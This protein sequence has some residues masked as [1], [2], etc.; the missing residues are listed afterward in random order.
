MAWIECER[1]GFRWDSATSN[2]NN[3]KCQSCRATRART[4][5]SNLGK[6]HPWHNDFAEDEITPVDEDGIPVLTGVRKCGKQDCVNPDH[7][8]REM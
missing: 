6:C 8:E 3:R 2:R 7:V 1:C 5:N 4:V